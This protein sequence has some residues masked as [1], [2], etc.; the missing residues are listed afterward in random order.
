MHKRRLI[1][2][3]SA[4]ALM[5][6]AGATAAGAALTGPVGGSGVIYGC[7]TTK[8]VNGTHALVLQ[9]TGTTCPTG[10]TAIQWNQ[11]GP[12]GDAGA[13]G[14][15]GPPGPQGAQGP[16]GNTGAQGPQGP[17]GD[18]GP[19]GPPGASS[20]DALDG[21]ACNVGS[22]DAGILHVKYGLNSQ[23][24]I[25]C[26]PATLETLQ[27]SV[28]GGD[29]SDT[30]TSDLPGISC[31]SAGGAACSMQLPRDTTIT[32]T[33]QADGTDAF[34]GWS[35]GGCSGTSPT[36]TVTMNQ[37]QSVTASFHIQYQLSFVLGIVGGFATDSGSVG[38]G[39]DPGGY[40]KVYPAT[41]TL[42]THNANLLFPAG[43]TVTI[44]VHPTGVFATMPVNWVGDCA[45]TTGDVC[46]L[47][48]DSAKSAAAAVGFTF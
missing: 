20:L 5:L 3:G 11:Q 4:A 32:L 24:S 6:M 48:M 22:P 23:V 21:T 1:V 7:Y 19:P 26:V 36:C 43:T 39:I 13:N 44:T 29:G 16:Q 10:T 30:V 42:Q 28:T 40:V 18:Q 8:A 17:K 34:D 27:L 37:A 33:A 47:T 2:I 45:G 9:D 12:K 14:P 25:T 35:G 46:T 38:L 41:A 31:T 15:Q